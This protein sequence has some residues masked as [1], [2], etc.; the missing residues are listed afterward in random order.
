MSPKVKGT[1]VPNEPR[2]LP[3]RNPY[4]GEVDY[5]IT[6]PTAAKLAATCASL[7]AGQAGGA[8]AG[9]GM[10]LLRGPE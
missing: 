8:A 4:T 3:V 10:T 2:V 1:A 5:A 9:H 6:P 7:R